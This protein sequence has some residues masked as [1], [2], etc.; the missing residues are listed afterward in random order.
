MVQEGEVDWPLASK[1]RS[2]S[3]LQGSL[4]E[5]RDDWSLS[6]GRDWLHEEEEEEEE[7]KEEE[8]KM[9]IK[10][11]APVKQAPLSPISQLPTPNPGSAIK[12]PEYSTHK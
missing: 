10:Q 6:K 4:R 2:V 8:Q 3:G 11:Q 5:E 12:S 7:E 9:S 1:E